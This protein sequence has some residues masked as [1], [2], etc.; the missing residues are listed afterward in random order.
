MSDHQDPLYSIIGDEIR[1]KLLRVFVL[2]KDSLYVAQDFTK[3]LRKREQ[4][5]KDV[6][7]WLVEDG[8]I[9]KKKFSP[10]ERKSRGVTVLKGYGFNKRYP[11]QEFLDM[12]VRESLPTE[13]DVL[14]K[15]ITRLPGVRCVITTN[16]FIEK[17]GGYVD[18]VV[19]SLGDNEAALQDVVQEM[20]RTIGRELRCAFLTVNDLLHRIRTN[21]R[22]IRNILDEKHRVHLDKV[23]L[24]KK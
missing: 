5:I 3:T 2:N 9:V 20:E 19:A 24:P 12:L 8:L 17:R 1:V 16:M 14:A 4:S 6:L 11:H 13:N 21:D 7:R 15:K 10:A 22:F 18:I 23:G